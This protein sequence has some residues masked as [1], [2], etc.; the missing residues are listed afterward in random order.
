VREEP[1]VAGALL[2][3]LPAPAHRERAQ[4]HGEEHESGGEILPGRVERGEELDAIEAHGEERQ[5]EHHRLRGEDRAQVLRAVG[6]SAG[7]AHPERA[8][9]RQERE[10]HRQ[11][12]EEGPARRRDRARIHRR[13]ELSARDR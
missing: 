7:L 4:R 10:E 9:Q 6:R 12:E 8:A 1:Q 2:E 13:A 11:D 5:D 3:R